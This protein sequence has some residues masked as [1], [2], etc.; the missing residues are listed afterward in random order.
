MDDTKRFIV[1]ASRIPDNFPTNVHEPAFW[2]EL[3]RTVATFGF[4]EETLGK[5]IFAITGT[6]EIPEA[7]I[8]REMARWLPVLEH[9]LSDQL[10]SLIATYEGA[11]KSNEK[12]TMTNVSDLVADLRRASKLRNVICHGSWRAPDKD[13]QSRPFFVNREGE[14]FETS[15]G[16]EWLNQLRQHVVELIAAVVTNVSHMGYQFPGT[17]GPGTVIFKHSS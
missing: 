7:E 17:S 15:I 16:I 8:E 11:A 2:E 5:A 13:G 4:L 10:G 6:R 14:V 3:G 1:D 12:F 9:A